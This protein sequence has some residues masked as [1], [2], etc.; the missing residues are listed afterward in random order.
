M[1]GADCPWFMIVATLVFFPPD[2]PRRLARLASRQVIASA[3]APLDR[4]HEPAWTNRQRLTV[5]VL[6]AYLAV[7]LIVPLRHLAYPGDASWT[8]QGHLFAWHM[9][10][11]GKR[12]AMSFVA[13]YPQTGESFPL[14][15]SRFLSERQ[16]TKIGKD[17]RMI[18]QFSHFVAEQARQA[19]FEGVEVRA[20]VLE[21]LNGRKPQLLI[22]PLVNL[23]A[24]PNT[25]GSYDWVLPLREPLRD[26]AWDLPPEQ[27][28]Q[29]VLL[30]QSP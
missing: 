17:P 11:R 20:I 26:N 28:P 4:L 2:W 1:L 6:G 3:A 30:G 15:A 23:A 25:W 19:G 8:E 29:H 12:C 10:L 27:W 18:L 24:E 14:D 22:D 9:M 5:A 21:S 7:Q 13:T 16:V